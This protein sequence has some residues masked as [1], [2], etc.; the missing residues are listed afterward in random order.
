MA[1]M[2]AKRNLLAFD[3]EVKPHVKIYPNPPIIPIWNHIGNMAKEVKLEEL[4]R[5]EFW[6]NRHA[7]EQIVNDDS[8]QPIVDSFEWFRT[9]QKLHPFFAKSLPPPPRICSI[10]H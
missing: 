4:S 3:F 9:F 7:A 1:A 6:D 10:L 5:L 8:E 2:R